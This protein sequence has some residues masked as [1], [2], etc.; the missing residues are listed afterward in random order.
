MPTRGS[1]RGG[2][3]AG[4]PTQTPPTPPPPPPLQ[5]GRLE[6]VLALS[7]E[8]EGL[9]KAL[10]DEQRLARVYTYLINYHYLKG[11]PHLASEDG[12]RCLTIGGRTGDLPPPMAAPPH[13][14]ACAP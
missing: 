14:G 10:D 9:A 2:G 6:E 7:R 4:R 11:E 5:R 3:A 1:A 12:Q 8:A 13:T